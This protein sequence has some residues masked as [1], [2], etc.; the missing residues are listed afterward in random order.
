[1]TSAQWVHITWPAGMGELPDEVVLQV[2]AGCSSVRDLV[3]LGSTCHRLAALSGDDKLWRHHFLLWFR[4]Q[5]RPCGTAVADPPYPATPGTHACGAARVVSP[6]AR[7]EV[8]KMG[9]S[10]AHIFPSPPDGRWLLP[11]PMHARMLPSVRSTAPSGSSQC[12]RR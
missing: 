7:L 5:C 12:R 3:A 4:A 1:M 9:L 2:M 6:C 11:P 8:S 10:Y